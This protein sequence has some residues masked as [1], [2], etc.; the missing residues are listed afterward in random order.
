MKNQHLRQSR[1]V[2]AL[3]FIM[4]LGF[5]GVAAADTST[6]PHYMVNE[7][8]FGSGS[9]LHDCSSHYCAKTSAGDTTVGSTSSASF[10]AQS[11]SNTTDIPLL[12]V[13]VEG[14]NQD[15]G[16]LD[17]GTTGTAVST[18]K[19]RTYLTGGY[20]LHIA[21]S[22]PSQGTHTISRLSAL[23]TS[24]P[25]AEQFGINLAD[26]TSPNIGA[27]A[28]Q[29]PDSTTSFGQVDGDYGQP[30]LFMYNDGAQVAH[31]DKDSGETDYTLSMILNISNVT[32]GGHYAG[33]YSAVVVPVF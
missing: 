2:V 5:S 15:L 11:G 17:P 19:V 28:L 8:Q 27:S 32:P 30:D 18:I 21:G 29:V 20:A 33:A 9:S 24:Q 10:S 7:T 1:F 23:S 4:T 14:G 12:E 6:S 16:V 25:G 22:P 13:I 31:S 3:A 26:N